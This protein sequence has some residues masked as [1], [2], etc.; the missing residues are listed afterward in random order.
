[1]IFQQSIYYLFATLTTSS[2]APFLLLLFMY[3]TYTILA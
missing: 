2:S 3:N 1:M